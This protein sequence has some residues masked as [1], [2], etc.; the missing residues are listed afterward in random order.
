MR[1]NFRNPLDVI[2]PESKGKKVKKTSVKTRE[3]VKAGEAEKPGKKTLN[4]E[5]KK[6]R[7]TAKAE[8]LLE[9]ATMVWVQPAKE[10]APKERRKNRVSPI[11]VDPAKYAQIYGDIL[12]SLAAIPTQPCTHGV[13]RI[14]ERPPKAALLPAPL[15]PST[16]PSTP[17]SIK[18]SIKFPPLFAP[19]VTGRR[20]NVLSVPKD[21]MVIYGE[22]FVA[23]WDE[24]NPR[25]VKSVHTTNV[26]YDL[27]KLLDILSTDDRSGQR[28]MLETRDRWRSV[29]TGWERWVC[30]KRRGI[31]FPIDPGR[32]N[33][34]PRGKCEWS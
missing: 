12:I 21:Q 9:K 15:P 32:C 4:G 14:T 18:L 29:W 25:W 20:G 33:R 13:W 17:L 7:K 24:D 1:R 6:T 22:P 27:G 30:F 19:S 23:F 2:L 34:E 11:E 3:S 5:K 31:T 26:Q 8:R 28:T 10:A 16:D